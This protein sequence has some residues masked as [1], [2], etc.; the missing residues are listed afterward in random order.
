MKAVLLLYDEFYMCLQDASCAKTRKN[1]SCTPIYT[2][3]R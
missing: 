3:S 2:I 1:C